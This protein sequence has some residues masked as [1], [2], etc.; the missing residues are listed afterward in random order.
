MSGLF[1]YTGACFWNGFEI[2]NVYRLSENTILSG[3]KPCMHPV[4]VQC[5]F[6]GAGLWDYNNKYLD[7]QTTATDWSSLT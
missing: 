4:W 2:G 3:V 6:T 5:F 7:G 1:D